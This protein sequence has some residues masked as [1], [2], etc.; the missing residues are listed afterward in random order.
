LHLGTL[1]LIGLAIFVAGF[2]ALGGLDAD[3]R[4]RLA[5]LRIPFRSLILR[6][7]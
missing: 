5:T 1:V 6:Y 3:D 4:R 2:K 7:L